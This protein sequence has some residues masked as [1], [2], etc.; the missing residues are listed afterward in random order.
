MKTIKALYERAKF[1][2]KHND[3]K[4]LCEYTNHCSES[5]PVEFL[6]NIEYIVSNNLSVSSIGSFIERYGLKISSGYLLLEAL[7]NQ[8]EKISTMYKESTGGE[9][10]WK[11]MNEQLTLLEKFKAQYPMSFIMYSEFRNTL[12]EAYF[13][14]QY[15]ERKPMLGSV[16]KLYDQFGIGIIPDLILESCNSS[17]DELIT[18]LENSNLTPTEFQWIFECLSDKGVPILKHQLEEIRQ[19]SLSGIVEFCQHR[20]KQI[21]R[22]SALT[23]NEN[24][25]LTY[26]EVELNA[27]QDLIEFKENMIICVDGTDKM[28]D[29]QSQIYSLYEEFEDLIDE[30]P[31]FVEG[32]DSPIALI[33]ENFKNIRKQ[34]K[35]TIKPA[36]Y[37]AVDEYNKDKK[38]SLFNDK[39]IQYPAIS[40]DF[41]DK[42]GAYFTNF[43]MK[44]KVKKSLEMD[45]ASEFLDTPR[46]WITLTNTDSSLLGPTD[47]GMK[48]I[49]NFYWKILM[50]ALKPLIDSKVLKPT[51]NLSSTTIIDYVYPPFL[52]GREAIMKG[53]DPAVLRESVVVIDEMIANSV[54]P[55]LPQSSNQVKEESWYT[56]STSNKKTGKV[57]G[58]LGNHHNLGYG[59]DEAKDKK[60][61]D[62]DEDDDLDL[63]MFKRPSAAKKDKS[64]KPTHSDKDIDKDI[65][66]ETIEDLKDD[67]KDARTPAEKE[68]AVNNYY[69]YTYTNSFNKDR[70]EDKSTHTRINHVDNSRRNVDNSRGKRINSD[71]TNSRNRGWSGKAEG[72]IEESTIH[73][74]VG[75]FRD[76]NMK[77]KG[78]VQLSEEEIAIFMDPRNMGTHAA[79]LKM[80]R[81][82][83]RDP[84]FQWAVE[85][86]DPSMWKPK[87]WELSIFP[88]N[89]ALMEAVG[90]ADDNKPTTDFQDRL[91]DFDRVLA[92]G[93]QKVKQVVQ[94]V[95]NVGRIFIKPAKRTTMWINNMVNKWK[96]SNENR[97]KEKMTDPHQR[98]TLFKAIRFSVITGSLFKAK[99]LFNPIFL[100]L[101]LIKK[102][103]DKKNSFRLRNEIIGEI[104]AELEVI[105]E[106][107]NDAGR[108]GDNKAKY[109]L[110]RFRN[111]L[112]K[113]LVRVGGTPGMAKSI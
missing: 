63:D 111:E 34:V 104:K 46:I 102:L 8:K 13:E 49:F 21:F 85:T 41:G 31:V 16:Q 75:R 11:D 69:Y 66:D 19:R 108:N 77:V 47:A 70:K 83:Q 36:L 101:A 81:N 74:L 28:L 20:N 103:G 57:P 14:Y 107:I 1:S 27:I 86:Y 4:E 96:D 97:V 53:V 100:G 38:F 43:F 64:N 80:L 6:S 68:R 110:I 92:Q 5:K 58:Y 59:E 72:K 88:K 50:K 98:G 105:E 39:R 106:K 60:P 12:P 91:V 45:R 26:S 95:S 61:E 65:D 40:V 93:G 33:V 10:A 94:K 3:L 56:T 23:T 55:M 90:D 37:K 89:E 2:R 44:G 78:G 24:L 99:L 76:V 113:K 32:D 109:Q 25:V 30:Y 67:I 17:M 52:I 48:R 15:S 42:E 22:E 84:S 62:D 73:Q 29:L 71:D 35:D 79:K 112:K 9:D 18:I 51:V 54:I 7:E 82:N 87:P